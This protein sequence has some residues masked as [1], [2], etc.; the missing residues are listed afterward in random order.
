MQIIIALSILL[1]FGYY[2][3]VFFTLVSGGYEYKKSLII[4]FIP[5]AGIV[6][7][8]LISYKNLS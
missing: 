3:G 1:S 4:D 5:F 2:F 7:I 8:V 6:R